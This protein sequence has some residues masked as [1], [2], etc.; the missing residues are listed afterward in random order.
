[1]P[2][3]PNKVVL[4]EEQ[5]KE[6]LDLYDRTHSTRE[7]GKHLGVD[8]S[9]ASRLLKLHGANVLSRKEAVHYVWKNHKHPFLGKKGELSPHFGKKMSEE[10]RKKMEPIWSKIGDDR[11]FGRKKTYGGYIHIYMPEHPFAYPDGYVAEHRHVMEQH[12]GRFLKEDEVVH[13]KNFDKTDNSIENLLLTNLSE[14]AKIHQEYNR[15]ERLG[16]GT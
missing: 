6:M 12:I 11:R 16:N 8:H 9:V 13:H 4:T 2:N 5:A 15:R 10:H 14:H 3:P 1:M 7:V